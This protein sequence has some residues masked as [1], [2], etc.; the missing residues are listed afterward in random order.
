MCAHAQYGRGQQTQEGKRVKAERK[1][2][3][4]DARGVQTDKT[5]QRQTGG[6][7][8]IGG[9]DPK[10][11]D[12]ARENPGKLNDGRGLES[13]EIGADNPIE[14]VNSNTKQRTILHVCRKPVDHH[15]SDIESLRE[16]EL[17]RRVKELP[18]VDRELNDHAAEQQT[19]PDP[20]N[21]QCRRCRPEDPV[22]QMP[23]RVGMMVH[24]PLVRFL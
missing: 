6:Q 18:H 10:Q 23:Y 13:G 17:V 11:C 20:G 2:T 4:H 3:P 5:A 12:E 7:C 8:L 19:R 9:S 24:A 22:H 15:P 21:T 1:K 16:V 14:Q